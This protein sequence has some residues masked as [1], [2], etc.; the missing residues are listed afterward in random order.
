M[1][2][3]PWNAGE[4]VVWA[5]KPSGG[6]GYTIPVAGIVLHTT[7]TGRVRIEIARKRGNEWV[8]EKRTVLPHTL[9]YRREPAPELG[10]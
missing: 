4:R 5:H 8:R 1:L 2:Q 3:P 10:E 7:R 9:H 6:Y